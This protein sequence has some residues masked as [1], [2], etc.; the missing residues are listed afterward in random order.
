MM[1]IQMT[2]KEPIR[3]KNQKLYTTKIIKAG[4]LLADTKAF[5]AH[6]DRSR[7]VHLL[8]RNVKLAFSDG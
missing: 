4:A 8:D 1:E 3:I 2:N 7:M 6:W 5:L